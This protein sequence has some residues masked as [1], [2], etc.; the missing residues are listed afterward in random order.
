MYATGDLCRCLSDGTLDFV[1][2]ADSQVKLRGHRIELGEVEAALLDCDEIVN[3]A[4]TVHEDH[5]GSRH[6]VAYVVPREGAVFDTEN[7]TTALATRLPDY[8]LPTRW[9]T[10]DALPMNPNGKID[11]RALPTSQNPQTTESRGT[12]A[13]P[14]TSLEKTLC[15]IWGELLGLDGVPVDA[16]FR[17]LGGSSIQAIEAAARLAAV[18]GGDR[19]RPSPQGQDSVRTYARRVESSAADIGWP[20]LAENA[21]HIALGHCGSL[22]RAQE[23]VCFLEHLDGAWRAYRSHA[24]LRVRGAL[25]IEAFEGAIDDLLARHD[26]LR[27][28]FFHTG[29]KWH[30]QQV[31]P[32]ASRLEV[33]DLSSLPAD[34][35]K[36]ALEQYIAR[37][38]ESRFDLAKPPMIRWQVARLGPEEHFIVQSEHHSV[39]DGQSFRLIVRDLAE[40]Y[41]ARVEDRRPALPPVDA[42]YAR[43]CAEEQAW[44]ASDAF[45]AQLGDWVVRLRNIAGS[46]R[47]LDNHILP[48]KR[49][50]R[51]HQLRHR[52]DAWHVERLRKISREVGVSPFAMSLAAFSLVCGRLSRRDR[53][54][55]GTA[56]A[57]RPGPDYRATVG[58]FVNAVAIQLDVAG[59]RPFHERAQDVARELDFVLARSAVPMNEVVRAL[60]LSRT[61]SGETPFN[62]CFSFHDSLP[63]SPR[64]AGLEVVVEEGVANGS[65]KFDLSVVGI[66]DNEV[67]G[68][69]MELLFEYDLDRLPREVVEYLASE[70]AALLK[71]AAED[72]RACLEPVAE[73]PSK[74][75]VAT[76]WSSDDV[77]DSPS[78]LEAERMVDGRLPAVLEILRELMPEVVTHP[79]EDM[80]A[81][82]FHSLLM[83]QF[84]VRCRDYFGRELLMQDIYRLGTPRRIA[85]ALGGCSMVDGSGWARAKR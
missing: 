54:L 69:G 57:N 74:A 58:M 45:R 76:K 60:N 83:M 17:C 50:F 53:F 55:V 15:R 41:S 47:V 34:D 4:T 40:L 78:M 44:F 79:D 85:A 59:Q 84:V 39:H 22:S 31:A 30:R 9:V 32:P 3:V 28:A 35:Q 6:L 67:L 21:S 38:L 10:M 29:G 66:L 11:R 8:M 2:R 12:G 48:G 75:A 49:R 68:G 13:A 51:G 70:L 27:S 1:G 36:A 19:V 72:P 56:V 5:Q 33:E 43:F 52:I 64:F 25:N 82:G 77:T 16:S 73:E 14:L 71:S 23:Q 26:V 63:L 20:V 24:L 80:F 18:L 42:S 62:A 65:A 61:L 7:I 81:A 46:G 37:E